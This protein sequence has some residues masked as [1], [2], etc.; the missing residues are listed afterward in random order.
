MIKD[1]LWIIATIVLVPVIGILGGYFIGACLLLVIIGAITLPLWLPL[2]LIARWLLWRSPR[3]RAGVFARF[4]LR[5]KISDW[6]SGRAA[7]GGVR[8]N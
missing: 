4:W 5:E 3:Y 8:R 7:P 1:G 6:R 2:Y